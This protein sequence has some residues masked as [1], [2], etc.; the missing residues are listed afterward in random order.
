MKRI[1]LIGFM[2]IIMICN[3]SFCVNAASFEIKDIDKKTVMDVSTKTLMEIG[4]N[5]ESVSDYQVSFKADINNPIF[6]MFYT[7]RFNSTQEIWVYLNFIQ[8]NQDVTISG[9]TKIITNPIST[10]GK[11]IIINQRAILEIF[12]LIKEKFYGD[13]KFGINYYR[14]KHKGCFEINYVQRNSSTEKAGVEVGDLIKKINSKSTKHM[15]SMTFENY[16]IVPDGTE[17]NLTIIKK[18]GEEKDVIIKKEF[19]PGEYQNL[20]KKD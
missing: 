18:T 17:L 7:S 20:I 16:F 2:T 4:Y 1:T 19:I 8:I 15:S 3:V 9:D 10:R 11:S 6:C 14:K 13:V 5:I 12:D